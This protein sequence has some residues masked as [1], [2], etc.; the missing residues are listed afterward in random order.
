MRAFIMTMT[1]RRAGLFADD[2]LIKDVR[3]TLDRAR[4]PYKCYVYCM[5]SRDC[6][7]LERRRAQRDTKFRLDKWRG[8]II[9]EFICTE[10]KPF[11][12]LMA[13]RDF[14]DTQLTAEEYNAL[15]KDWYKMRMLTISDRKIYEKPLELEKFTLINGK[16]VNQI[17]S[18]ITEV[19]EIGTNDESGS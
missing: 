15:R 8:K 18:K 10:E 12:K 4:P 17:Y 1:P 11:P 7:E 13:F 5:A 14:N 3:K 6:N 2:M 19:K 16:P 9:G